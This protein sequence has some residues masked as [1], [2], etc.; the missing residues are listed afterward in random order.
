MDWDRSIVANVEGGRRASVAV[1]ELLTLSYVLGVPPV[2]LL[3]PLDSPTVEIVPGVEVDTGT[4][5][6]WIVGEDRLPGHP[7]F[8]VA[9]R[10]AGLPRQWRQCRRMAEVRRILLDAAKRKSGDESPEVERERE[11]YL[12]ALGSLVRIVEEAL[13]LGVVLP[14]IPADLYDDALTLGITIPP[15]IERYEAAGGTDAR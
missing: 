14:G 9:G 13:D 3:L 12:S 7:R 5:T 2:A 15:D 4:A 11:L 8:G 1:H 10:A 6:E